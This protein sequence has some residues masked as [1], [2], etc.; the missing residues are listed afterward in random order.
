MD[1]FVTDNNGS[2]YRIRC[3]LSRNS[4]SVMHFLHSLHFYD[5]QKLKKDRTGGMF[6]INILMMSLTSHNNGD[7]KQP[8][9]I[10]CPLYNSSLSLTKRILPNGLFPLLFV[11]VPLCFPPTL[12]LP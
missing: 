9:S 12:L 11:H 1:S 6:L 5:P 8:G 7:A 3:F 4:F 10:L 2:G